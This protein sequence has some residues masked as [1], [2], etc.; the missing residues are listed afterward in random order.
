MKRYTHK[1]LESDVEALN[2]K[3]ANKGHNMRFKTGA[4]NGYSAIDLARAEE[5]KKGTCQRMLFGGSPRECLA[6][7]HEYMAN[8]L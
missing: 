4:R 2:E 8:N 7:C 6:A 1:A 3:L 5:M